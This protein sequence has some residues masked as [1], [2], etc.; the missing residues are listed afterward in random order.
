[1]LTKRSI[2]TAAAA[3]VLAAV[4]GAVLASPDVLAFAAA[5]LTDPATAGAALLAW[6]PAVR[7]LQAQHAAEIEG[8]QALAGV[9]AERDLTAEEQ[10]A[11]NGHKAKAESLKA[12]I[13]MAQEAESAAAGLAPVE[14]AARGRGEGAVQIAAGARIETAEN[15]DSDPQRGFRSMGDYLLSVRGATVAARQGRMADPRLSALAGGGINAAAPSTYGNEAVGEDGGYLVPPGFGQTIFQLSLEE[16]ALL[17]M[18]DNMPVSGNTMTLPKDETTPWGSD[19]VRAYWEGE[20]SAA[21]ATK[22]KIGRS[23]YRL[24]KLLALV[25]MTE[26][27]LADGVALGAYFEPACARSIRW[28]TD[29]AILW[30]A[31]GEQP[32]G[33]FAGSAVVTQAKESGQAAGTILADNVVKMLSRLPAG[34]YRNAV[35]MVN[36]DAL[37]QLFVMKVGDTPVWL[38]VG[39]P[40]GAVSGSPYG[41]LFGRPVMVT[42]HAKSIGTAG[43]IMLA[44]LTQYRTITKAGGIQTATSM[45]LYF[46]ADATAFRATFRVDGAPK[47]AAAITPANG[48]NTMSPFVMLEAR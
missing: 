35:W 16:D 45:H 48:S 33:A 22:P 11:Y 43:D 40:N 6:G 18:T 17:P 27:L 29:E 3:L 24:R 30:G 42:Q 44:D 9:L 37:P 19:G 1:M 21:T 14:P 8:M 23:E 5:L 10:A 39:A 4:S 25:P 36:N 15:V 12:R 2:F 31:A 13:N 32:L 28:K 46:D 7:N 34:A 26:E 41:T 38:P 20:A 47:L